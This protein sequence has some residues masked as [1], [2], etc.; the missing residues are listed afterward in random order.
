MQSVFFTRVCGNLTIHP[1]LQMA[2][3][4]STDHVL[5]EDEYKWREHFYKLLLSDRKDIPLPIINNR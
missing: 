5:Y 3:W 1:D 2:N 4:A